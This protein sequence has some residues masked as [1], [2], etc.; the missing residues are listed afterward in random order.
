MQTQ[1][2]SPVAMPPMSPPNDRPADSA[3]GG[4]GADLSAPA[5]AARI[6]AI[7]A[8]HGFAL[9]AACAMARAIAAGGGGMAQ[10]DH[11]AFGGTGQWMRG[12]MV[13]IG[14]MFNRALAARV[15][16]LAD[17]LAGWLASCPDAEGE[18]EPEQ[19]G[20]QSASATEADRSANRWW[21]TALGEPDSSG[22]QNAVRYAYFADAR[23][24]A[25]ARAGAVAVYD[26][27]EHRIG[28]VSQSQGSSDGG[29][30]QFSSQHGAVDLASLRQL[31]PVAVDAAQPESKQQAAAQTP[32]NAPGTDSQPVARSDVLDLLPKLADLHARGVLSDDEFTTKKTEL[33]RRI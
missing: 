14:D 13:M 32:T 12:G 25:V 33:L 6:E 29:A 19:A 20:M 5:P 9:D 21:P 15:G 1:I 22:S 18:R 4:I 10:F 8:Q 28:G 31:Q 27:G 2:Q 11:P 30:L 23:R 16:A 17:D 24:L 3:F 26:T 7:G